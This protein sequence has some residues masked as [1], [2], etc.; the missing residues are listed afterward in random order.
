MPTEDLMSRSIL[1]AA[2]ALNFLD[3]GDVALN[4]LRDGLAA[5]D[6]YLAV[7]AA[8]ILRAHVDG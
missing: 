5:A 1:S 7:K 4:L 2:V 3:E 6:V 8:Q